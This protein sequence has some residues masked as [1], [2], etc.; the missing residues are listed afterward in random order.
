[1]KIKEATEWYTVRT[2]FT[3]QLIGLPAHDPSFSKLLN[4]ITVM[5]SDLSKLEVRHRAKPGHWEVKEKLDQINNAITMVQD[6]ILIAK[7]K[8]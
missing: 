7:L 2:S 1:M 6:Y 3:R 5:V 4:N 8:F